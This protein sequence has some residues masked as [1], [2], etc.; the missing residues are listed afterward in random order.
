MAD[1]AFPRLEYI[2]LDGHECGIEFAIFE[3]SFGDGYR[4]SALVGSPNGLIMGTITYGHLARFPHRATGRFSQEAVA[5]YL[6]EFFCARMREGNSPFNL[7]FQRDKK[8]YLV[9]FT[10]TKLTYREAFKNRFYTTGIGYQQ[11]RQ[12]GVSTLGDGSVGTS[13]N[14]TI[15]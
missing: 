11:Y 1:P 13:E 14:N 12:Q 4:Q 2:V 8:D 5:D 6:W 7:R 9:V 15:I 10:D 3:A